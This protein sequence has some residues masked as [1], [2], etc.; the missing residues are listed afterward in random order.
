MNTSVSNGRTSGVN[1]VEEGHFRFQTMF[2]GRARKRELT[3]FSGEGWINEYQY[4]RQIFWTA[5]ERSNRRKI[6]AFSTQLNQLRKEGL[7]KKNHVWTGFELMTSAMPVHQFRVFLILKNTFVSHGQQLE[8]EYFLFWR[9]FTPHNGREKLLL[10]V[11]GLTL[12]TWWRQNVPKRKKNAT[13]GCRPW[14]RN[15]CA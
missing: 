1:L 6:L 12:Q 3:G 14:L 9:V 4:M 8:V 10:D 11:C 15:V 13:S 5:D 2:F 7:E